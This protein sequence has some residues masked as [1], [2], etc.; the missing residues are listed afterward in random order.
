MD[1]D[2]T[3][4]QR[5]VKEL[6]RRFAEEEV[7]PA[8][9]ENER[10]M[11]FPRELIRRMG[12]LGFFGAAFPRE[13]GGSELG[14]VCHA[15]ICEEV[16]RAHSSLRTAFNMQAMTCAGAIFEYGTPEQ[17]AKYVPPLLRAEHMGLFALT[18]PNV[19]SDVAAIECRAVRKGDCYIVNGTKTW[20]S[21][22]TV[23]DTGVVF[24]RTSPQT[25]RAGLSAM[26]IT[27]D[28]P[29]L[30]AREISPKMGHHCSPTG[31]LIFEDAEVPA[32]NLLGPENQGFVIAMRAL[33]RGRLS[34][35]AGAV[36]VA[37]ACMDV[38]VDYA[39]QR[40]QF[41][42]PIAEY[43]MVQ[44]RIADMAA[45]VEAARLL[46]YRSAC[47]KD[48]GKRNTLESAIAKYVASEVAVRAA[49][50][51]VEIFGGNAY[52]EEYPV[53]RL[54]RDA[55]LYQIGEGASN[56]MRRLIALDALGIKKANG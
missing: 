51:A 32:E 50:A 45:G 21:N 3:P 55:K 41:G 12:E 6:A 9:A 19:G 15:L 2:L 28:T 1:F 8:V 18:E 47:L 24:V 38:S 36:G 49:N 16:S 25:G 30:S 13:Y 17:K 40:V 37:Q 4:E 54:L 23:F 34:V 39:N 42:K 5:Q 22:A 33:D 7:A 27:P 52:S 44:E 53:S 56:I 35:A 20:I 43:Q 29:G 11:R 46:V 31:M 10:A 14:Y 48:Q 26:I